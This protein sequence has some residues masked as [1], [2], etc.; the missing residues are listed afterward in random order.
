MRRLRTDSLLVALVR[1]LPIPLPDGRMFEPSDRGH[2]YRHRD[3]IRR[4]RRERYQRNR[5]AVIAANTAYKRRK[6]EEARAQA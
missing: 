6:R 4:K 2:Y 3:E 1:R 5:A